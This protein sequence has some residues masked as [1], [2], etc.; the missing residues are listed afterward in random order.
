LTRVIPVKDNIPLDRF[1]FAT[2]GLILANIVVYVVAGDVAPHTVTVGTVFSSMFVHSS[3]VQLIGNVWFLWLFGTNVEDSMGPVR[4]LGFYMAGGL[5]AVGV[6]LAVDP[7]A[8]TPTVGA[9]GAV[10]AVIGGYLLL[11]PRARVLALVAI[12]FFFG[13]FEIPTLVL[14]GA[15]I[16]MQ[17]AFAAAGLI[18]DGAVAYASYLGGLAFGLAAI[19][20]LAT[21]RKPTPPTAAAYR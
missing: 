2:V 17:A 21:R 20:L 8:S 6:V 7:G 16:V 14:L 4:F 13:V 18:G 10:A 11:Y 5:A 19:R 12:I 9:A 1:P 15:W 3:I